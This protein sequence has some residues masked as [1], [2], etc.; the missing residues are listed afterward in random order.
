[1]AK[2]C[3]QNEFNQFKDKG[4]IKYSD[5]PEESEIQITPYT[6]FNFVNENQSQLWTLLKL[7]LNPA[8]HNFDGW[9]CRYIVGLGQSRPM[10]GEGGWT[11]DQEKILKR[12]LN[13][14]FQVAAWVMLRDILGKLRQEKVPTQKLSGRWVFYNDYHEANV[15]VLEK[16]ENW[17]VVLPMVD[18]DEHFAG[19]NV[20]RK[21]FA[22]PNP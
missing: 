13:Y 21:D 17:D 1:M 16:T 12:D 10:T 20:L 7:E 22:I 14:N 8:N 18:D 9:K 6:V 4:Q 15:K 2:D 11:T 5:K 19:I 3:I